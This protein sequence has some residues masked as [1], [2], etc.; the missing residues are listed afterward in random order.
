[1]KTIVDARSD[2]ILGFTAFGPEAGELVGTVQL[3]MIAGAPYTTLRDAMFAH[4]TM[5][6]GLKALFM[7]VPQRL[8]DHAEQLQ[9]AETPAH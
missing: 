8:E 9:H 6:E 5:T 1:M 3:A 7:G 4:P 2:S